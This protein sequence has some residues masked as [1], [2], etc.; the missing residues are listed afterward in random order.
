MS[1]EIGRQGYVGLAIESVAGTPEA[2]PATFIPFTDNTIVAKHE[3]VLDISARASRVKDFNAV[4]G[5]KW[6]EGDLA[7]YADAS[8]SGY[9]LK[10]A[11]GQEA[12]S[13]VTGSIREHLFYPTVSGNSPTSATLWVY[14]GDDVDINQHAYSV[15]DTLSIE[16][17]NGDE[18]GMIT[19][20]VIANSPTS[21]AAPTLS[22][23]SGNIFTFKDMTVQFGSSY[24]AALAATATKVQSFSM[25]LAN[26]VEA[27]Y[28][29]GSNTPDSFIMGE[30]EVT[31]EYTVFLENDTEVDAYKN[32]EKRCI[33]VSFAGA[34]IGSGYTE[35]LQLI[36]HK[37]VIEDHSPAVGLD[38]VMAIT[39]SFRCLQSTNPNPGYFEARLRNLKTT[40]Y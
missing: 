22:T 26:N 20:S 9:L 13:T 12:M 3:P 5:K 33:V 19:A 16:V 29:S 11:L 34:G 31:G 27:L 17:D 36:F 25:E 7:M 6:A 28:R 8:Q 24:A 4:T 38:E 2:S 21:V 40:A 1:L 14:R 37:A 23:V 39:Q 18:P 15:V 10:L 35:R 30:L 32:L